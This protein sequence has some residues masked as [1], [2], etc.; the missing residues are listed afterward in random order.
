MLPPEAVLLGL[1]SS[2]PSR[3]QRARPPHNIGDA[4]SATPAPAGAA[5]NGW[6]EEGEEA[7]EQ[8]PSDYYVN[9]WLAG[10]EGETEPPAEERHNSRDEDLGWSE[11]E[12][13]EYRT[14]FAGLGAP[15]HN[16]SDDDGARSDAPVDADSSPVRQRTAEASPTKRRTPRRTTANGHVAP[17]SASGSLASPRQAGRAEHAQ[18][19][20]I[21]VS[22]SCA[23]SSS[24]PP[25]SP[26]PVRSDHASAGA[27]TSEAHSCLMQMRQKSYEVLG[28]PAPPTTGACLGAA[29]H[30]TSSATA[31]EVPCCVA[32][33]PGSGQGQGGGLP[34]LREMTHALTEGLASLQGGGSSSGRQ[35][36]VATGSPRRKAMGGGGCVSMSNAATSPRVSSSS[37]GGGGGGAATSQM[38]VS[39]PASSAPTPINV[40]SDSSL[41]VAYRVSMSSATSPTNEDL[42]SRAAHATNSNAFPC[43]KPHSAP[44]ETSSQPINPYHTQAQEPIPIGYPGVGGGGQPPVPPGWS[45]ARERPT[46]AC[47][48]SAYVVPS[49]SEQPSDSPTRARRHPGS[50]A[51]PAFS[52]PEGGDA[53]GGSCGGNSGVP[54]HLLQQAAQAGAGRQRIAAPRAGGIHPARPSNA[55]DDENRPQQHDKPQYLPLLHSTSS[56]ATLHS[57]AAARASHDEPLQGNRFQ[58]KANDEQQ[59]PPQRPQPSA[60]AQ[61]AAEHV[62]R[63]GPSH[64]L[65]GALGQGPGCVGRSGGPGGCHNSLSAP[66]VNQSGER[67]N[68]MASLSTTAARK[69]GVHPHPLNKYEVRQPAAVIAAANATNAAAAHCMPIGVSCGPASGGAVSSRAG[70]CDAA[71]PAASTRLKGPARLPSGNPFGSTGGSR[72]GSGRAAAVAAA[73]VRPDPPAV[74]PRRNVPRVQR[75]TEMPQARTGS[76]EGVANGGGG[77]GG[78][79]GAALA[80]KNRQAKMMEAALEKGARRA[81]AAAAS[82]MRAQRMLAAQNSGQMQDAPVSIYEE[83]GANMPILN[84]NGRAAAAVASSSARAAVPSGRPVAAA[85][86]RRPRYQY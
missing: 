73:P 26:S 36:T 76:R 16:D 77:A 4:P 67:V 81:A 32:A 20:V 27:F 61:P 47:P 44:L 29:Q 22:A 78:E 84:P 24:S 1:M 74:E 55:S 35:I 13:N 71:D 43:Q 72:P 57:P 21:D 42:A 65:V 30:I 53:A 11:T 50:T 18:A 70:G 79:G 83:I 82:S 48:S 28:L 2:P 34:P 3:M 69:S 25:E 68:Q 9:Y 17:G 80:A 58:P 45:Q 12:F 10:G 5:E 86:G 66:S 7:G 49:G 60:A 23:N 59:Q 54:A 39:A 63:H 46:A 14:L 15:A 31:A 19:Q 8:G 62:C 56:A 75:A 37:S 85:S 38:I 40:P 64:G 6:A 41:P 33:S 52:R 51:S